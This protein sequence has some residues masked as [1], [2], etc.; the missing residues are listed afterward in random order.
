M[1]LPRPAVQVLR[2]REP[3][4]TCW[5]LVV[6]LKLWRYIRKAFANRWNLLGLLGGIGFSVISGQPEVG[7]PLVAAAEL[8]WLGFVGTHPTFQKYV[9]TTEHQVQQQQSHAASELRMKRM[10][11]ALPRGAQG[12]YQNLMNQCQELRQITQ[13]FQAAHGSPADDGPLGDL[14]LGGLDKLL[15]LFLKLLYTE[16]SLN[17]FFETTSI[18][19]IQRDLKDVTQRLQREQE[20][21]VG[22]QR[23]RIIATLQDNLKT[24]EQRLQNFEQA[25]D[26]FE[27]VKAEQQRLESRIRSLAEMGIS[28]GDPAAFSLQVDNVA[29][30]VAQTE[31]TLED[32]QFVT[33]FSTED[34]V[35]P[36]IIPRARV[37]Q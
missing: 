28:R 37:A 29:G 20:R 17:R 3:D 19:Q 7:L 35:V 30:S 34:E 33:G 2:I 21:P 31:K 13:Q 27:L 1:R 8:A 15:W 11:S 24:C 16:H 18:E 4:E 36:E 32:L 26:S 5:S 10:F 23:D 6:P 25:R 9:D 12:R 22:P 14:R